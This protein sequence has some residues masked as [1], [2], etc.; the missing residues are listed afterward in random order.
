MNHTTTQA[1]P[2]AIPIPVPTLKRIQAALLTGLK[3]AK[4]EHETAEFAFDGRES[5][6]LYFYRE[7]VE[8]FRQAVE[9]VST[10]LEVAQ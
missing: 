10:N 2:A 6:E 8:E 9:I 4:D 3:L 1:L 5:L 7:Q